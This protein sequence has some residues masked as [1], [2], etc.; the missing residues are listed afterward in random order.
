MKDLL[1]YVVALV[2]CGS[3][4]YVTT[5]ICANA[6][7]RTKREHLKTFLKDLEKGD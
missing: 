2:V 5:R 1:W 4:A 3:F 6:W 7:F